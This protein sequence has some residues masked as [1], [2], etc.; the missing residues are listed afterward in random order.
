MQTAE[1]QPATVTIAEVAAVLGVSSDTV[2]RRI[3]RRELAR[4]S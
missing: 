2:R 4:E 3:R 1:Q